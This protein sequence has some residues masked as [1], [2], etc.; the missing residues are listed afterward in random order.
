MKALLSL[1]ITVDHKDN[2]IKGRP[3]VP[4]YFYIKLYREEDGLIWRIDGPLGEEVGVLP[5]PSSVSQ[6]KKDARLVYP[7]NSTWRPAASWL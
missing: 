2:P 3:A 7:I 1:R 4:V 5:R 6:A